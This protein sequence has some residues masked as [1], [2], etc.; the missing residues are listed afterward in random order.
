MAERNENV[1]NFTLSKDIELPFT[2]AIHD[3]SGLT[4]SLLLQ[5][6]KS[7]DHTNLNDVIAD[8][9]IKD[10]SLQE[11][12]NKLIIFEVHLE[13]G[14][15]KMLTI[16]MIKGLS[17]YS[18]QIK[19]TISDMNSQLTFKPSS[20]LK[21]DKEW[22]QLPLNYNQLPLDSTLIMKLYLMDNASSNK[23]LL[24]EGGLPV[25]NDNCS[26]K[27]G[28]HRVFIRLTNSS[29]PTPIATNEKDLEL[30]RIIQNIENIEVKDTRPEWLVD[31]TK[32]KVQ[33]LQQK[34]NQV[35]KVQ[36]NI[37]MT[38]EFPNFESPIIYSDIK[39]A[40]MNL[41]SI[42]LTAN[43]SS[44]FD[45]SFNEI[46][47]R[48]F[49]YDYSKDNYPS[50]V[51]FDPDTVRIEHTEDPIE[52]KFRRLE[53]IQHFSPLDKDIKPTLKVRATL[54]KIMAKQFFEKISA[55]ERNIAWKYRWFLLNNL[56]IGNKAGWNNFTV[57]FIKCV[58]WNNESEV[59][60]FESILNSLSDTAIKK[61][62]MKNKFKSFSYWWVFEQELEIIDCLEL[63]TGNFRHKIIRN[64][65]LNR[66]S[67]AT[68]QEIS[69]FMVQLVQNIEHDVICAEEDANKTADTS[70]VSRSS[71]LGEQFI[72]EEVTDE[73][74]SRH[75]GFSSAYTNA[76]SDFQFI[77][78]DVSKNDSILIDTIDEILKKNNQKISKLKM[79]ILTSP[80]IDFI[81][82]RAISNPDLTYTFYWCLKVESEEELINYGKSPAGDKVYPK[83][84]NKFIL[85]LASSD[86]GL[87]KVYDLRR[88]IEFVK[89]LH[90]FC[91]K[92]KFDCKKET[93]PKKIEILKSL[94]TEKHK[95]TI[96]SGKIGI[97]DDHKYETMIDFPS[98]A[99]PL[100]PEVVVCGTFA[101]ESSVFKSS[102]SP[103]KL[104]FKTIQGLSYPVMYKIGDD[105]RQDQFIT[106]LI[107]LI[108]RILENENMDMKLRPYK[109][110]AT[111]PEEGFIQFVPNSS[112]SSILARYN[113]SILA[114]LRASNPDESAPLGVKAE[115]MDNYVRS[116]AGYC[117]VT[118]IL[119]IGD[120]HLE[121]LLLSPDGH[122][123][124]ADFGYIL[125]QDPKP[126]PPLMKLPIQ[127]IEGMGGL[128]NDNY[129]SFCQL[130]FITYI[131]LRKNASLILNLV[132]LMINTSIP[133]L[134]TR[135]DNNENEKQEL[136][137][138]VQEKFMLD[139]SDEGAVLH[140]QTL[141][142]DSV[143]AVLPVVIDRL[144]SMAQ[145]WRA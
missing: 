59:R 26:M 60:D 45:P 105:L 15:G 124:H 99:M 28:K 36:S 51:P 85:S 92:I 108:E 138:K 142:D 89:K 126:F 22:V 8:I 82:K 91:V 55:K 106:Q 80:L 103:I 33:N 43:A 56:V 119:G 50:I 133:A 42:D 109:I 31:M 129:K 65:A 54:S 145:Y 123:F 125:G 107:A 32:N 70:G 39:Y 88:Q 101:N 41:P 69:M 135:S 21:N 81:I 117:V 131:T 79:P 68:D 95:R 20:I 13:S 93:T 78:R 61:S 94:L 121:N 83:V 127:I 114:F 25:F 100:D 57:N 1:V 86:E 9:L 113:N 40:T 140:F 144:H 53:R 17:C 141:I 72:N 132:Q 136:L 96:L 134:C 77:D 64:M 19:K 120:R 12:A 3:L 35:Y 98:L 16:P 6:N 137:W 73:E 14:N 84:M 97:S 128:S 66:L 104:S 10:K 110:L 116:C 23:M 38:L 52:Q 2:I 4:P 139:I 75:G 29:L 7:P 47:Y 18:K 48:N 27:M 58:D 5:A 11:I 130:C 49:E 37:T 71:E 111:G 30:A 67:H 122:F 87:Q 63:L 24:G 143:N 112:L 76:S 118:Y 115:V 44:K 90:D 62:K 46:S 102:L 34:F 74:D